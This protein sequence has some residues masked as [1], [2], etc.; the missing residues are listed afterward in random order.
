MIKT[1]RR[2]NVAPPLVHYQVWHHSTV[3]W[4]VFVLIFLFFT[5]R[6]D[7]VACIRT[8]VVTQMSQ[9]DEGR[10][11]AP[12]V[13]TTPSMLSFVSPVKAYRENGTYLFAWTIFQPT[14]CLTT[15]HVM[16]W[17]ASWGSCLEPSS[18]S[19]H[20]FICLKF[21]SISFFISESAWLP[22]KEQSTCCPKQTKSK[23][24]NGMQV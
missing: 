1:R 20:C 2:K 9:L 15:H 22:L 10:P 5:R 21:A 24:D 8:K 12:P 19:R 11:S 23:V 3:H 17:T 13:T 4:H 7:L 16:Y 14:W 6:K 18:T